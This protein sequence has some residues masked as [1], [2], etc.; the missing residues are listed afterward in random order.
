[1]A[2]EKLFFHVPW[3]YKTAAITKNKN[4][5]MIKTTKAIANI[6]WI[7]PVSGTDQCLTGIILCHL[8]KAMG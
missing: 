6:Y 4:K 5:T 3:F 1:M 8:H 2:T 7:L